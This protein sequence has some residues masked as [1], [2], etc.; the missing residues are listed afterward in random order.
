MTLPLAGMRVL[1]FSRALTGPYCTQMFGDMGAEVIKI[2]Q[3]EVGDNSRAW[4]PPFEGGE[5]SYYLSVNRNK[6]SISINMRHPNAAQILSRLVASCDVLIENFVPGTLE[7]MGFGY[8]ACAVLRPDIIYCSISGFGQVGPDR[9]RAAYDQIAQGLG[10]LMS[11]TGEPDGPPMRVGIAIADLVAGMHAAYAVMVAALHREKTGEGQYIDTSLLAG[12]LAIMTYQAARYFATGDAPKTSGNHHPTISPYG[13]YQAADAWFNLAVGSDDLWRRFCEALGVGALTTDERFRTNRLRSE[14]RTALNDLLAPVFIRYTVAQLEA[15]LSPVGI[16]IG[17]VRDLAAAFNDPQ[18]AAL[19][20]IQ[21]I[22]HP[23]AG[24]VR[25]VGPPY[26]FSKTPGSIRRYPPRLGEHND[27][28]LYELG[29]DDREIASFRAE[30][31]IG[32]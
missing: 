15:I 27:E 7:R 20:L 31:V 4:G 30:G 9:N 24:A 23:T 2:E 10:G 32:L 29:F 22:Q 26:R 13:V 17:A 6:R 25:V 1:D 18:V 5:S 8:A 28:L 16:P 19:D 14:H 12:Q 11:V 21:T 3:P